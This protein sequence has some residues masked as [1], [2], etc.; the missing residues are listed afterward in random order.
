MSWNWKSI[1]MTLPRLCQTSIYSSLNSLT[2]QNKYNL[3]RGITQEMFLKP[4][5]YGGDA[6]N[7]ATYLKV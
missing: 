2:Y 3:I 1:S 5:P 6:F 7:F 4:R